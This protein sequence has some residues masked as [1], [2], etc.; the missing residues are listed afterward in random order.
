M[1]RLARLATGSSS[2]ERLWPG[3]GIMP[4]GTIDIRF[5]ITVTGSD[6]LSIGL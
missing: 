6:Q 4:P 3:V 5:R 2:R 1:V